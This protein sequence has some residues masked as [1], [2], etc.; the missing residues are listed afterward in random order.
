MSTLLGTGI[1]YPALEIAGLTKG[2]GIIPDSDISTQLIRACN[3]MLGSWNCDGHKIFTTSIDLHNLTAGQIEYTIGPGGQLDQ[4][5]P[6]FIKDANFLFPTT[7]PVRYPIQ[8][9]DSHEWSLE[10]LQAINNAPP[11]ALWYDSGYNTSAG[12]GNLFLIGQPPDDYQL[13]LYTWTALSASF[14]A[15]TD[16]VLFPPGYEEALVTNLAI[17][18]ASLNPDHTTIDWAVARDEA[19]KALRALM[20]LNTV[21]PGIRNE[22]AGISSPRFLGYPYPWLLGPYQ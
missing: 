14:T 11:W 9:Y 20:I 18:A 12:L 19:S 7:P 17:K 10:S 2:P 4:A 16:V 1:I 15:V 21:C 22:A 6:L 13:E 8:I 5:R 3:R